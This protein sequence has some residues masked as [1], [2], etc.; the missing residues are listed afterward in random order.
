MKPS[1]RVSAAAIELIK[2]FEGLRLTAEQLDDGR[3]TIGYGHTRSAREGAA[4]SEA[5]AEALLTYD[6]V[7]V[8]AAAKTACPKF[9]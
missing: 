8:Q 6:L 9:N 1:Y 2:R 5:D 7:E 4:V 3:W